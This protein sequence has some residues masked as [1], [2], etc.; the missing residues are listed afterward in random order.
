M[1]KLIGFFK[2]TFTI[3]V[4]IG[5]ILGVI[6]GYVFYLEVGCS[7]H[8]CLL[9]ANPWKMAGI[10]AIIGYLAGYIFSQKRNRKPKID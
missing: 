1:H 8:S 4:I 2:R 10:G 3:P 9:T 6:G 5:M 7:T